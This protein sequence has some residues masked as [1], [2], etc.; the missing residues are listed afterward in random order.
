MMGYR[1]IKIMKKQTFIWLGS[2]TASRRFIN[3]FIANTTSSPALLVNSYTI[4][5]RFIMTNDWLI[6]IKLNRLHGNVKLIVTEA[7]INLWN[8]YASKSTTVNCGFIVVMITLTPNQ[9]LVLKKKM[10]HQNVQQWFNNSR[11]CKTNLNKSYSSNKVQINMWKL[12]LSRQHK[13]AG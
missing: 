8:T 5:W 7:N 13:S 4:K 6:L 9:Y 11:S 12:T 3:V 2:E 1:K 10:Q